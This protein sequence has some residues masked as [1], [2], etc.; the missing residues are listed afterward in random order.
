MKKNYFIMRLIYIVIFLFSVHT[1]FAQVTNSKPNIIFI[2]ADDMGHGEVGVFF[3]NEWRKMNEDKDVPYLMTPQLDKFASEGAMLT[4]NYCNAPVC[5]PSRASLLIG[6][7]QGQANVRD[8]QFDKALENNYTIPL[9]LKKLGYETAAIGKWGLQGLTSDWPAHPLNRGFDYFYGYIRHE[10]GHEDYPKEG[11]VRGKKE[12]Y[13]NRTNVTESLDKCYTGDLFTARAKKY[14][15]DKARSSSPFFLYLAF[16]TPHASLELPTQKYPDGMGLSGGLKWLDIQGKMINTASG[17]VD[18]YIEP[19][20]DTMVYD[21]DKNHATPSIV[22]PNVYKRYGT[23]LKRID[24]QVGDIMQLL[25]DLNI[26]KNTLVVFTADNG[27]SNESYISEPFVPTFFKNNAPFDG[28]KR[29]VLEGG[30]R[31]PTLIKWSGTIPAGQVNSTPSISS[32]WMNT[33]LDAAGAQTVF[34]SNGVSLL[35]SLTGRGKQLPSNVYIEYNYPG[36]TPSYT[37]WEVFRRKI[38]RN[39]MQSIRIGNYMG[40]RY[41]IQ[42]H[43]DN[44]EKYDVVNDTKQTKNLAA[45]LPDVQ[46]KMKDKV[47]QSRAADVSAPRPYDNELIPG[48]NTVGY[49]NNNFI[50]WKFYPGIYSWIPNVEKLSYTQSGKGNLL[51]RKLTNGKREGVITINGVFEIDSDG[52]YI[53][54]FSTVKNGIV[55]LHDILLFDADY[56]YIP[57]TLLQKKIKLKK[58]KHP[59][60]IYYKT[61]AGSQVPDYN[62]NFV[63]PLLQDNKFVK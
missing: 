61:L 52:E 3:Q 42:N 12:M 35:P 29:D 32:D 39:Q 44:F 46:A 60:R 41:N 11:I 20:F 40:V 15:I 54:N 18:S 9:L 10:D 56:G 23:I 16:D 59:Y 4:Q 48:N 43:G 1:I 33:F 26:D 19:Q 7:H 8:N 63:I 57:N 34:R 30:I 24:Y 31:M 13:E 58:G 22:I 27:Q 51:N 25:K 2:L 14:I 38:P 62:F 6:L 21:N 36:N 53:F 55:K 49:I 47:L 37:N 50:Q 28:M 45:S 17:T 5:A